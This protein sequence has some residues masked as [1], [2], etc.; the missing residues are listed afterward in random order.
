MIVNIGDI[1]FFWY[2]FYVHLLKLAYA[3]N[4]ELYLLEKV[5]VIFFFH[6]LYP[7]QYTSNI[8]WY[9]NGVNFFRLQIYQSK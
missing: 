7:R 1:T 9:C 6:N 8:K 4:G 3:Q 2:V 5:I